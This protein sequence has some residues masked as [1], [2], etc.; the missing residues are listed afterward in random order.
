MKIKELEKVFADDFGSPI[1][2]MLAD[3]YYNENQLERAKKFVIL[4]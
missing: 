4:V 1:F 2:P 3:Y